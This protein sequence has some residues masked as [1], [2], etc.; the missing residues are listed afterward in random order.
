MPY[1]ALCHWW[2]RCLKNVC[3]LR[4]ISTPGNHVIFQSFKSQLWLHEFFAALCSCH[5]I[6]I[7]HKVIINLCN[8]AFVD[9]SKES[10]DTYLPG[11][12]AGL[13][14]CSIGLLLH[15][16]RVALPNVQI[17]HVGSQL[18]LCLHKHLGIIPMWAII[19]IFLNGKWFSLMCH[20]NNSM[21]GPGIAHFLIVSSSYISILKLNGITGSG[22]GAFSLTSKS[23]LSTPLLD[24]LT[25]AMNFEY[26]LH[27]GALHIIRQLF[28]LSNLILHHH[29]LPH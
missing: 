14:C 10:T 17:W 8:Y 29:I 7:L 11:L 6:S 21:S 15:G 25:T 2:R 19:L 3:F 1:V 22:S 24:E 13:I 12:P 16:L 18:L 23:I 9:D 4:G 20:S 28:L 27:P 5:S 26:L